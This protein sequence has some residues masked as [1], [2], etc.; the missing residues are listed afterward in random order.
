MIRR[1]KRTDANHAQIVAELRARGYAV[2]DLS[3]VGRGCP[4]LLVS[5]DG[6]GLLVE[7]KSEANRGGKARGAKQA[8][9]LALQA[10]WRKLHPGVCVVAMTVEDVE[11]AF[12]ALSNTRAPGVTPE[13][14]R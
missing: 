9:T 11:G 8:E 1:A 3:A 10:L 5:K 14:P 2:S 12:A 6:R 4:D 13:R 7:I